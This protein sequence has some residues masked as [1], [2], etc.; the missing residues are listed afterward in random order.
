MHFIKCIQWLLQGS[1]T[2]LSQV[3]LRGAA[4]VALVHGVLSHLYSSRQ[5]TLVP[6]GRNIHAYPLYQTHKWL[7]L[8]LFSLNHF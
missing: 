8:F 6:H 3:L 1:V 2:L 5:H 7:V 4:A